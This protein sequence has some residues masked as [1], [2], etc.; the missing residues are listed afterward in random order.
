MFRA[1]LQFA[2]NFDLISLAFLIVGVVILCAIYHHKTGRMLPTISQT[3]AADRRISRIFQIIMTIGVPVFYFGLLGWLAPKCHLP[4]IFDIL[5]IVALIF[6]I[7]F[8]WLPA[9]GLTRRLHTILSLTVCV[10]MWLGV[11]IL[12]LA[13]RSGAAVKILLA[14]FLL[15]PL[16]FL[17]HRKTGGRNS[18]RSFILETLFIAL[19][20]V[21]EIWLAHF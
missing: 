17:V 10:L 16:I 15:S 7:G 14:I 9:A 6:E 13:V 20:L 8:I 12:F 1:P 5:L 21:I 18:R 3:V 19:F 2:Q 4:I 11:L